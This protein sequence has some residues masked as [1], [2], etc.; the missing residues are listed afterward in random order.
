MAPITPESYRRKMTR[1]YELPLLYMVMLFQ[2]ACMLL[3]AFR[4]GPVEMFSLA[5]SVCLPVGTY[6]GLKILSRFFYADRCIYI[7]AAFL[8]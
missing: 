7:L 3:L 4:D 5:M 2:F 1:A 6:L 8:C